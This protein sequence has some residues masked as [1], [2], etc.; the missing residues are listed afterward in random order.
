[1]PFPWSL[2]I[3]AAHRRL[4][5]LS[6][7]E[8][9]DFPEVHQIHLLYAG[10]I[11]T[12]L[13]HSDSGVLVGAARVSARIAGRVLVERDLSS[14]VNKSSGL[15]TSSC[16]ITL[17]VTSFGGP[18]TGPALTCLKEMEVLLICEGR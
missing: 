14:N 7:S 11:A 18:G 13:S 2:H 10:N 6:N 12:V 17:L 8:L 16:P 5:D 15:V 3:N 9:G 1:M 4:R